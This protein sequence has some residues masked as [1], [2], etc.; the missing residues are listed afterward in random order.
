MFNVRQS[1]GES[2]KGYLNRFC[3]IFVRLQTQDEEM[4]VAAF[5]QG[6]T[7]RPFSNSLIRNP[8]ETLSE[9]CER[10]NTHIEVEEV[11]LIKNGSSRSKLLI[12]NDLEALMS[13]NPWCL[14]EGWSCCVCGWVLGR[15]MC[16]PLFV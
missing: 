5:I 9:V 14:M 15:M 11:V 13:P 6:M 16:N 2:L 10:A 1:E 7:A 3:A 12:K 8:T 4:V